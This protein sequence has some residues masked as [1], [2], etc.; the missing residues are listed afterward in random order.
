MTYFGIE[1]ALWFPI[2]ETVMSWTSRSG[3]GYGNGSSNT[4]STT[5]KIA[6]VEPIPRARVTDAAMVKP[7]L[8]RSVRVA[9]RKSSTRRDMRSDT[10]C[11]Q[12]AIGGPAPALRLASSIHGREGFS[13]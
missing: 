4:L 13:L 11:V 5:E 7:G 1:T 9:N 3:S 12:Q 8:R 10:D 2:C 6:A